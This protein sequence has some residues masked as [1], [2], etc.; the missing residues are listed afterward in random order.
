MTKQATQQGIL[1]SHLYQPE[2][3]CLTEMK[4][5]AEKHSNTESKVGSLVYELNRGSQQ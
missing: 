4:V 5:L 3:M 2:K 1:G